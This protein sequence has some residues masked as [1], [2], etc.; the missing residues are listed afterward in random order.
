[1]PP[2]SPPCP[3]QAP[4]LSQ[5][6]GSLCERSPPRHPRRG[7]PDQL[8]DLWR[9]LTPCWVRLC[10][11]GVH[12]ATE[13]EATLP[14]LAS[15]GCRPRARLALHRAAE[16]TS[17]MALVR[18][19]NEMGVVVRPWLLLLASTLL[20]KLH[21]R[22]RV[23]Q[24]G[25]PAGRRLACRGPRATDPRESTWRCRLARAERSP[26]TGVSRLLG[27]TSF[28]ACWDQRSQ[29]AEATRIYRDSSTTC[30]VRGF[31]AELST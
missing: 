27:L 10:R 17:V 11:R 20:A 4:K 9:R 7:R 6:R 31:R 30:T 16:G 29:Y 12:D 1:M 13:I 25:S 24:R 2:I 22:P 15:R 8:H 26:T 3:H 19:A 18:R 23:R 21:Q 5:L 14:L 28:N